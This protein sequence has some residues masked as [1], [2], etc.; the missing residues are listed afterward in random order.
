MA[1]HILQELN[2]RVRRSGG[3][4]HGAAEVTPYAH[5]PGSVFVGHASNTGNGNRLA[6]AATARVFGA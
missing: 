5:A 3:E 6:G 4:L 2:F 1:H